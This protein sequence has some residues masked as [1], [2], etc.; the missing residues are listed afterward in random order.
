MNVNG[1]LPGTVLRVEVTM[2]VWQ[3]QLKEQVY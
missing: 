2:S 3:S 1:R